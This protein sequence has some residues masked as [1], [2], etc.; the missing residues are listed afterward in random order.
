MGLVM[1]TIK[2]SNYYDVQNAAEGRI[3]SAAVRSVELPAL[4]DT[5]AFGLCIPEEVAET[6]GVRSFTTRPART[7]DG[8]TI[9]VPVVGPLEIEV[10]GRAMMSD[11]MVIPRGTQPLLG[12]MQLEYLD[13][14]V[15]PKTGEIIPNP[16]HPD[17]P[18]YRI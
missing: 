13:L 11:A 8:R 14:V 3:G 15:V 18:V 17:G 16:A 6:L 5:G 12:A 10:V 4:A 2:I 1:T 9:R 7:A